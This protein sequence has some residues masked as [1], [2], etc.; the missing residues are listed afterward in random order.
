MDKKTLLSIVG[1]IVLGALGSGLWELVKPLL[2]WG[3]SGVLTLSTLGLD[4]LRNGMYA[5]TSSAFGKPSALGIAVELLGS[6]TMLT[7]ASVIYTIRL[8]LGPKA[9]YPARVTSAFFALI[10]FLGATIM[11]VTNIRTTYIT[12]LARYSF[13]LETIAAPHLSDI[14]L[15]EFRAKAAQIDSRSAYLAHVELLRKVIEAA[16]QKAPTR[17]FF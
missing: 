4:S 1:I 3:L 10:L 11:L 12:Q 2:G 17:E 5:G 16:G 9:P 13:K 14:Q 6:L 8:S 15:K 7:G